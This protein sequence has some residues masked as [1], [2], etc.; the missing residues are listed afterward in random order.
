MSASGYVAWKSLF[1]G[2]EI[3]QTEITKN[4]FRLLDVTAEGAKVSVPAAKGPNREFVLDFGH[5]DALWDGRE[6][7]NEDQLNRSVNEVW[8]ARGETND[9][10]HESQYWALVCV[11]DRRELDNLS[12]SLSDGEAADGLDY[13]PDESDSRQ[14]IERQIRERRGQQSF[15]DGLMRHYGKRCM[16]SGCSVLD[17]LEA[18][19]I[20]PYRG[21][22]DNHPQNGLLLRADIHTLFDLHL[23]GIHPDRLEVEIVPTLTDDYGHLVGQILA[24]S[25]NHRPSKKSLETHYLKFTEKRLAQGS[26]T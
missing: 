12:V 7:V 9:Y 19:H 18:A 22:K 4:P 5:L 24:C 11:R 3:V 20:K 26:A 21:E 1:P 10:T 16:V 25:A 23:I 8:T 6:S 14:L 15:R 17:V 13:S 2:D